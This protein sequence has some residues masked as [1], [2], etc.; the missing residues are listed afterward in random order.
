MSEDT[1]ELCHGTHIVWWMRPGNRPTSS[2]CLK[3]RPLSKISPDGD[4]WKGIADGKQVVISQIERELATLR[5]RVTELEGHLSDCR[6][7]FRS[8]ITRVTKDCVR[9]ADRVAELEAENAALIHDNAQLMD[10]CVEAMNQPKD[11][12]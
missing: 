10:A 7:F 1:C 8:E 11:P 12:T 6:A 9:L 3:C 4:V 2:P 5:A